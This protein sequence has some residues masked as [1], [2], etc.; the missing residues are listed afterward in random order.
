M[1]RDDLVR[2]AE[3]SVL[4]H[5]ITRDEAAELLALLD[6][7]TRQLAETRRGVSGPEMAR[8][9]RTAA[10]LLTAIADSVDE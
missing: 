4:M 2:M 1:H 10:E 6:G 9:L 3:S 7:Q 8:D 5:R